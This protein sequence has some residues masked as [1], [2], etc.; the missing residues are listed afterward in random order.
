MMKP[1]AKLVRRNLK[2]FARDNGGS[3]V[4]EFALSA[5]IL[6]MLIVGIMDISNAMRVYESVQTSAK[7]GARFAAIHGSNSWSPETDA[8]IIAFAKSWAIGIAPAK[9]NVQVV[10]HTQNADGT[11]NK[12]AGQTVTVRAGLPYEGFGVLP[13]FNLGASST[14]MITN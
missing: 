2:R 10:W 14:F 8:A 13:S 5:V 1:L 7:E 4:V 11:D 9:L 3:A 12:T 6:L